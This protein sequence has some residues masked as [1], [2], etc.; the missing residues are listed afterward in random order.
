MGAHLIDHP[1]WALDLGLPTQ[2]EATSTPWGYDSKNNRSATR[3]RRRPFITRRAAIS[4]P[5][6]WS[7]STAG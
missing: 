7:G 2:I 4:R 1:F 5:S 3:W 6:R